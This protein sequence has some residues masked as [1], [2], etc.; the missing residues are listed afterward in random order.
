MLAVE[1]VEAESAGATRDVHLIPVVF[2]VT[3]MLSVFVLLVEYFGSTDTSDA[4]TWWRLPIVE[5]GASPQA[6]ALQALGVVDD[7]VDPDSAFGE[8]LPEMNASHF[9]RT[10]A[11]RAPDAYHHTITE[12]GVPLDL[13]LDDAAT[14][15]V[16]DEACRPDDGCD[17]VV[18][19]V[20]SRSAD[21]EY[22]VGGT[23]FPAEVVLVPMD[24]EGRVTGEVRQRPVSLWAELNDA[25]ALDLLT[26]R[27]ADGWAVVAPRPGDLFVHMDPDDGIGE[28]EN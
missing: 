24:Q 21:F 14:R 13:D 25:I 6:A 22:Q 11:F 17:G 4:V 19:M 1:T 3:I 2:G 7:Q 15:N 5:I 16:F 23:V 27:D 18:V 26:R 8:L 20:V 28:P 10:A 12:L 9:D